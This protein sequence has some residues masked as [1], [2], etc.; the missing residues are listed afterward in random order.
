MP[1]NPIELY[2]RTPAALDPADT[3]GA[4][5]LYGTDVAAAARSS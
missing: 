1:Q 2:W 5:D 3:D 4:I